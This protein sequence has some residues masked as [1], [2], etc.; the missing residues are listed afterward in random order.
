MAIAPPDLG[1]FELIP[2]SDPR[3]NTMIAPFNDNLLKEYNLK[4]RK[5]LSDKM[6]E[7][8]IKYGG[9]GLTCNQIGLPFNMFVMGGHSKIEN[10]KKYTCINPKIVSASEEQILFKEGCLTFPFLF[11]AIKRP[12]TVVVQYETVEGGEVE[13]T[14]DGMFS[15]IYQHEYDHTLGRVFTERVSKLKLD[16]AKKKADKI[17]K[18]LKSAPSN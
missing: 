7:V 9:I 2:P 5:E 13:E 1:P 6:F 3:V 16:L 10:G 17:M 4:D 18:R 15:R 14:L 11:L 12:K 8:M